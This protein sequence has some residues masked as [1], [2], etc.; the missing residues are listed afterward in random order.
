[1]AASEPSAPILRVL[2]LVPGEG[3]A[4][5]VTGQTYLAA[6]GSLA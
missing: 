4:P 6:L 2:I 1:M 5:P 3:L